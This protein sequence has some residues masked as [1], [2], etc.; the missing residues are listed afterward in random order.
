[1]HLLF[2]G[3]TSFGRPECN[4]RDNRQHLYV[5]LNGM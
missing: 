5:L 1:M 4:N 2:T 3:R